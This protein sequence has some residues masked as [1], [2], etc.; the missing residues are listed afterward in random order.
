[1]TR[2]CSEG[3]TSIVRKIEVSLLV[4]LQATRPLIG[5]EKT[6]EGEKKK[7]VTK[8]KKEKMTKGQRRRVDWLSS[9]NRGR[10]LVKIET[11]DK[12]DGGS[13]SFFSLFSL[14]SFLVS[15]CRS[16]PPEFLRSFL[17][18]GAACTYSMLIWTSE[19]LPH[20]PL[21]GL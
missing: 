2:Y 4:Y 18:S 6:H 16:V 14:F 20:L 12:G 11:L 13:L 19:K 8:K 10:G 5:R 3:K 1:M 17:S 15:F 7:I 21:F 9:P